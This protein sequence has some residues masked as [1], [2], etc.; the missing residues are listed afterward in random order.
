MPV[1]CLICGALILGAIFFKITG[2]PHLAHYSLCALMGFFF[3]LMVAA[4]AL[5]LAENALSWWYL[6][7]RF[8][9]F[10][11]LLYSVRLCL[12]LGGGA[13]TGSLLGILMVQWSRRKR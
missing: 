8:L 2:K 1:I 10:R 3:G 13:V 4:L 11:Q 12:W 9:Q 5:P 6:Q 7:G